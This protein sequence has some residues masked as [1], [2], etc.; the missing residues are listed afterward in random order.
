[1]T[2]GGMT[3]QGLD[4]GRGRRGAGA[5]GGGRAWRTGGGRGGARSTR[6][7]WVPWRGIQVA[8]FFAMLLFTMLALKA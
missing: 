4:V 5:G 8:A 3:T 6:T 1:M 7:G 2:D